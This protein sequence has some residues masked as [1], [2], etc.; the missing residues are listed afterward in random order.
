MSIAAEQNDRRDVS[1]IGQARVREQIHVHFDR[2]K[3]RVQLEL[4]IAPR[5]LELIARRGKPRNRTASGH[6]VGRNPEE[7]VVASHA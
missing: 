6:D 4:R 7:R 1:V 2:T 5:R 3:A